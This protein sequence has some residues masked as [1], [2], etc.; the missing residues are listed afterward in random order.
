MTD[1]TTRAPITSAGT[2]DF[3]RTQWHKLKVDLPSAMAKRAS[4]AEEAMTLPG[5]CLKSRELRGSTEWRRFTGK[6]LSID[7]EADEVVV[8]SHEQTFGE[9]L[10]V[11]R[12]TA[13]QYADV[14]ECD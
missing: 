1:S 12:G 2:F 11:W 6:L 14:W 9:G 3:D 10:Y 5:C 13:D 8:L 7:L 4:S